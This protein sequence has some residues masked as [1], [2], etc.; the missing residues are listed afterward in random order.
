[1]NEE[2]FKISDVLFKII[3]SSSLPLSWDTFTEVYMGGWKGIMETDPKKLMKS[4]QFIG[5]LKEE[6]LQRQLRSEKGEMVNQAFIL[7]QS[8]KNRITSKPGT[9]FEKE[10]CHQCGKDNHSTLE[11]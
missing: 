11:C 8:L 6:Y 2:D 1:M 3:I 4:Q 7:K 5:I 9:S 10:V